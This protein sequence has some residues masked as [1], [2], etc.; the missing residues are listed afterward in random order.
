[1]FLP[2]NA[3]PGEKEAMEMKGPLMLIRRC[4]VTKK[5]VIVSLRNNRKVIGCV[6]AYDRH[7][8]MIL[9]DAVETGVTGSKNKGAKKRRKQVSRRLGNVFVRGDTVVLVA[10]GVGSASHAQKT[11]DESQSEDKQ[12]L[13]NTADSEQQPYN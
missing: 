11:I 3:S 6:V 2:T 4:M 12:Q 10:S 8:N 7:Y 1:M 5:P 13:R 9:M